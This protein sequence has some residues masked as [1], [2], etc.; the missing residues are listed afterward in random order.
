L[1]GS[2]EHGNKPSGSIKLWEV[3]EQLH[4]W[5]FSRRAHL[6]RNLTCRPGEIRVC[7]QYSSWWL[8]LV[9]H[10]RRWNCG[11]LYGARFQLH[12]LFEVLFHVN[13]FR[14][15]EEAKWVI[16]GRFRV[17]CMYKVS[18]LM[19]HQIS[20]LMYCFWWPD[21]IPTL[22]LLKENGLH[23][24]LSKLPVFRNC[25]FTRYFVWL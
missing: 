14:H 23:Q 4:H 18:S 8:Y 13:T 3:L 9:N 17:L 22:S 5:S 10:C 6:R 7:I 2:Y 1:Q 19:H 24:L 16:S 25:S 20:L 15:G 21:C 11:I 12:K